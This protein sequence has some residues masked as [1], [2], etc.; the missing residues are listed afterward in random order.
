MIRVQ[1]YHVSTVNQRS[2]QNL[3]ICSQ[4]LSNQ[5]ELN[6]I[7]IHNSEFKFII[8]NKSFHAGSCLFIFLPKAHRLSIYF[9][10]DLYFLITCKCKNEIFFV[11]SDVFS[12]FTYP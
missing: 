12:N 8:E 3:S 4:V 1:V 6:Q 5:I 2:Q 9:L 11:N 10:E 7:N